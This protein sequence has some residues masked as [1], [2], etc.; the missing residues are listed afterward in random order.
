MNKLLIGAVGISLL[1]TVTGWFAYKAGVNSEKAQALKT[2]KKYQDKQKNLIED[3]ASAKQKRKIVYVDKI[4]T[5]K[6]S[7]DKCASTRI[8][9]VILDQL[10]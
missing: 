10:R 4:R 8:S 6:A 3:L 2:I 5:I 9:P 7:N 1:I